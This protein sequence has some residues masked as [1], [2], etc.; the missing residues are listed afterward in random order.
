MLHRLERVFVDVSA[1]AIILLALLIFADVVALNLFNSSVPDTIVI[2][3]ELMVLAIVMPLAAATAQRAHIAVEFL[4]N[5][6]PPRVSGW[7]AVFGTLF[8]LLA[9]TPILYSGGR[10]FLHQWQTGSVF[11]GDL[12]LPQWP[13]RLAFTLGIALGWLRLAVMAAG[14]ALTLL[15][16]GEIALHKT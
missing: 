5:L 16:G 12:N 1:A 13:G 14:D 11:Y 9:L 7:L 6:L 3:R 8:G 2:V 4:T 15:R 10:E